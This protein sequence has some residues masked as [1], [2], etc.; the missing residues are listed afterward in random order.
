MKTIIKNYLVLLSVIVFL[1]SCKPQEKEAIIQAAKTDKELNYQPTVLPKDTTDLW[2]GEGDINSDTVLI[3]IEGGPHNE[4]YFQTHG[5]DVWSS[6]PNYYSYYRAHIHQVNGFNK[7]IYNWKHEF[8]HEM[9]ELEVNN[10]TEA[11]ARTVQYFK[12]RN[13]KIIIAG[14][15]WGAFLIQYY[16]LKYGNNADKYLISAGR[17]DPT[18]MQVKYHLKGYNSG[19][20]QDGKTM[21]FA[22]TTRVHSLDKRDRYVKMSRVKQFMKGFLGRFKF[23]KE[24]ANVDLS[25]VVYAY[26]KNDRQIGALT[27]K[28]LEFLKFKGVPVYVSDQGHAGP[29]RVIIKMVKEGKIKL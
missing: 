28:E 24:F 11:L 18:P 26:A 19:F 1:S 29:D 12:D 25:N 21:R 22:D 6:L 16:I 17:L 14:T 13:K 10:E 2:I 23:T 7:S 15:S 8:T 27:E 20:T 3:V 5:I 4:I 9:A